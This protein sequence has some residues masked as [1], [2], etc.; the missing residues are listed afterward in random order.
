MAGGAGVTSAA[1]ALPQLQ[2]ASSAIGSTGFVPPQA[3][4]QTFQ[5][6]LQANGGPGGFQ[7][8][9]GAP[10]VGGSA[11]FQQAGA[12]AFQHALSLPNQG[13]LAN[14]AT[15]PAQAAQ[16]AN[17]AMPRWQQ[18]LMGALTGQSQYGQNAPAIHQGLMQAL[19]AGAQGQPGVASPSLP[20]ARRQTGAV[21][22]PSAFAGAVPLP[23]AAGAMTPGPV[24]PWIMR[25]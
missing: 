4:G 2:G 5:Q 13:Q 14:P 22:A 21:G 15:N 7:Q 1:Q 6:A 8:F 11:G 24:P 3:G 10:A 19:S 18:G 12:Q 16:N 17:A 25:G 20:V 23:Q 9:T